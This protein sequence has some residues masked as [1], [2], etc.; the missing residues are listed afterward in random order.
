MESGQLELGFKIAGVDDNKRM[1]YGWATK[2]E[3]DKQGDIVDYDGSVEAFNA[4]SGNIREQ[5]DPKKAIGKALEIRPDPERKA[6]WT[7]VYLSRSKDGEDALT[8]VREGILTG[9]S[10]KGKVLDSRPEMVKDDNGQKAANRILRYRLDELSLVDNPACPSATIAMVKSADGGHPI[11]TDACGLSEMVGPTGEP[12]SLSNPGDVP[13]GST[14]PS[15]VPASFDSVTT[16]NGQSFT[17]DEIQKAMNDIVLARNA[18]VQGLGHPAAPTSSSPQSSSPGPGAS[19]S[20]ASLA[21][22]RLSAMSPA[23][24]AGGRTLTDVIRQRL[25]Q[26]MVIAKKDYTD[27]ERDKMA[28]KDEAEPDGSFPIKTR[29]DLE[30]AV[31]DWGRAGSKQ[32]DKDWIIRRAKELDA[33]DLLP[34]DWPGSTKP[35]DDDDDKDSEKAVGR[36][37]DLAKRLISK[38]GD[39]NYY[40]MGPGKPDVN[41]A[42]NT[43]R[44]LNDL[45]ASE[46]NEGDGDADDVAQLDALRQAV[47]LV[48]QFLASELVE[49]YGQKGDKPT[50]QQGNGMAMSTEN[51]D[52]AKSGARHSVKDRESIQ[53]MHDMAVTLGAMC[54]PNGDM[55]GKPAKDKPGTALNLYEHGAKNESDTTFQAKAMGD[56]IDMN[57]DELAKVVA[58][59]T[60][61]TIEKAISGMGLAKADDLEKVA[62]KFTSLDER[63]KRIE[64]QPFPDTTAPLVRAVEKGL[65]DEPGQTSTNEVAAALSALEKMRD[66]ETNPFVKQQIGS[67]IAAQKMRGIFGGR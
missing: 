32:K 9:F 17:V 27:P 54:D 61:E 4:W 55:D 58:V 1:V 5:H 63:L 56:E 43:I 41:A 29:N 51:G 23:A 59:A 16:S 47:Q 66:N 50:G 18:K 13:D 21:A 6:I 38:C 44:I 14:P 11:V 53:K 25:A 22:A 35:K 49:Y 7:G 20:A 60:K 33:T 30:N 52:L 8:K 26:E 57:R 12:S 67:A 64:K 65:G 39:S 31:H 37:A 2:E 40:T 62:E 45:L 24:P 42:A 3:L 36:F 48:L 34:A 46:S 19:G 15:A 10:I 28:D